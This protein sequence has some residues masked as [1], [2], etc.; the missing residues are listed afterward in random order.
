M[1]LIISLCAA[2]FY[3][4]ADYSGSRGARIANSASVTFVGQAA[5][6]ALLSIYLLIT[7]TTP[8]PMESWM[9]TAGGGFGGAIALVAF[10][11]AMS[12]GSM[13]VIAPI[14]AVIGLSVPVIAGFLQGERP[15][16]IAWVGIAIAVVAVALVGDVLDQHD[17]PTSMNAIWMAIAA[18]FGFG[19][20]F[21][22]MAHASHDHGVWPLFGQRM[23]SVPT[24]AVLAFSQSRNL[25]VPKRAFGFALI[26]GLLDTSANGLY[27]LATHTGMMSLVS[28]ITALYPVSTVVLA[29]KFDHERLHRSQT[30]GMALA[31]TSLVLVSI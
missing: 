25:G 13:T 26:A 14:T 16:T 19:M 30:V 17:L 29:M 27:L 23:V 1:T 18:G 15:K 2:L 6:L 21:V 7:W 11:Q 8:P 24:V 28:V 5:A 3:G 20:I 22:C 31:A 9:W 4:I 10:Y 12:K